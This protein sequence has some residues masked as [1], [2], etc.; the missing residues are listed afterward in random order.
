[1]SERIMTLHPQGKTGVA[2]DKAKYEV[3]KEAIL[4][5]VANGPV[6]FVDLNDAVEK[7]LTQPFEGSLMWYIS[8]IK[9]DLEARGL[10]QRQRRGGRQ[11][12]ALP[13]QST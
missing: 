2:I 9:L 13:P 12:V 3:V 7:Q 5:V 6:A 11:Y 10:V 4:A 8:T 1:M